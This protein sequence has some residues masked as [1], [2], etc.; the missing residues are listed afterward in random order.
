MAADEKNADERE[1][2][3]IPIEGCEGDENAEAEAV[4]EAADEAAATRTK[5]SNHGCRR[6]ERRRARSS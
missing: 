5:V 3:E 6:E 1:V 4:T 2:R